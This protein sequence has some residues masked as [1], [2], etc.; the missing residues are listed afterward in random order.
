MIFRGK[1]DLTSQGEQR[2]C[3]DLSRA[4]QHQRWL[5]APANGL[6][7]LQLIQ[8]MRAG[9]GLVSLLTPAVPSDLTYSVRSQDLSKWQV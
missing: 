3:T 9:H 2:D 8:Q 5:W 4:G 7:Q 1:L 6:A